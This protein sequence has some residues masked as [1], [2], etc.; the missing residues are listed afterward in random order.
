[1]GIVDVGENTSLMYA[2]ESKDIECVTVLLK[3]VLMKN[4][5]NQ[6]AR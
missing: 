6:T 1:M 5:S 3:E 4:K 2:I